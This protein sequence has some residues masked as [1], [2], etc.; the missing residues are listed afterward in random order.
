[1]AL[2]FALTLQL[3][4]LVL[5]GGACRGWFAIPANEASHVSEPLWSE[6]HW[7]EELIGGIVLVAY[8]TFPIWGIAAARWSKI[9]GAKMTLVVVT[10]CLMWFAFMV[11]L[12]P[13]VQ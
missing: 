12:L 11:A 10:E 5:V 3:A 6:P 2:R 9:H 7:T 8:M 1:V 13:A 4:V